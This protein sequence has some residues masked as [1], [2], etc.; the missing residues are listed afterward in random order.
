MRLKLFKHP[1]FKKSFVILVFI[2][3]VYQ[4]G[5]FIHK[6]AVLKIESNYD[7]PDTVYIVNESDVNKFLSEIP[8]ERI[9]YYPK[10]NGKVA[11][12]KETEHS[13]EVEKVIIEHRPVETFKFNP[14]TISLQDLE[15]L[16]FTER[17]AQS[18]V[19]YREK[20]GRFRRKS[21]FQKSYV[22]SDSIY[23]RLENYIVIP[24]I[25]LNKADS[26]ELE[27][28]PGIGKYYAAKIVSYRMEL[29]GYSYPEQLM[30]L[31]KFDTSKY[32]KLSDLI[33]CSKLEPYP[34]WELSEEELKK[35][36]YIRYSANK[37]ILF[38]NTFPK[39][40]WSVEML[41]ECNVIKKEYG[42]KLKKCYI[43]QP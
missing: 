37:I 17:Q 38:K 5:L 39:E 36:P 18:I 3:I 30:D 19:N 10:N 43:K 20:G 42:E 12:R 41:I 22:V 23:K 21:D 16:G 26:A 14:N 40:K 9:R 32:N 6:S 2:I 4:A 11:I 1:I 35:H 15:R 25:D 34:L 33:T 24:K 27:T 13:P 28:L 8:K 7:N 31:W 29:H